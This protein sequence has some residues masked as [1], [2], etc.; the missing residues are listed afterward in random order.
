M[1]ANCRPKRLGGLDALPGRLEHDVLDRD[2]VH[3]PARVGLV[4]HDLGLARVDRR[5]EQLLVHHV[6]AHGALRRLRDARLAGRVRQAERVA[7]RD[8]LVD[9]LVGDRRLLRLADRAAVRER[10]RPG[11]ERDHGSGDERELAVHAGTSRVPGSSGTE[12]IG[13]TG[14]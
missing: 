1:N 12:A 9:V 5:V 6:H 7:G 8:R 10:D 14:R 3:L 11:G 2:E 4:D 13:P